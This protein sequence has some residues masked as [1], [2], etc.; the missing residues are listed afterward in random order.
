ML[1]KT[2][3]TDVYIY[4][5]HLLKGEFALTEEMINTY[6]WNDVESNSNHPVNDVHI[7]IQP[8]LISITATYKPNHFISPVQIEAA[9]KLCS[10]SFCPGDHHFTF[11]PVQ[12]I[13]LVMENPIIDCLLRLTITICEKMVG[14]S[15]ISDVAIK[16]ATKILAYIEQDGKLISIVLNKHPA[17]SEILQKEVFIKDKSIR[18]FEFVSISDISIRE[19]VIIIYPQVNL[20]NLYNKLRSK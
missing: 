13:K 17:I 7:Y 18:P 2:S 4:F 6:I 12:N 14:Q 16:Y 19:G 11:Q 9:F 8:E 5:K 3:F 1:S 15:F 10:W 20:K